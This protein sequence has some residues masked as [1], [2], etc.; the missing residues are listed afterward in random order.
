MRSPMA[1]HRC[2]PVG[3]W[4]GTPSSWGLAG[5]FIDGAQKA[6]CITNNLLHVHRCVVAVSYF[7]LVLFSSR[8]AGNPFLNFLY[9]S[10]VEIPAYMVGRYMGEWSPAPPPSPSDC[11]HAFPFAHRRQIRT[12]LYQLRFVSHLVPH[13]PAHHCVCHR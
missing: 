12:T 13:L 3:V 4:R 2:L 7:T 11:S 9:Q 8:M 1:L 5:A 10:I 6:I